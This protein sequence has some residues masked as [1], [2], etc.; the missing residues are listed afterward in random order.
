[1]MEAEAF[2]C[3]PSRAQIHANQGTSLVPVRAYPQSGHDEFASLIVKTQRPEPEFQL[4][5][6][7]QRVYKDPRVLES[8]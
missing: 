7:N 6:E 1:M 2:F 4:D 8:Q 5:I 3:C